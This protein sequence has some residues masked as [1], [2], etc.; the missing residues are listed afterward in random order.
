MVVR[1]L[2]NIMTSLVTFALT[3][4]ALGV[5]VWFAITDESVG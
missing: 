4:L 3:I 2:N 1:I 5:G